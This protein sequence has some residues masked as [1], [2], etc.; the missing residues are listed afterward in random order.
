MHA[1]WQKICKQDIPFKVHALKSIYKFLTKSKCL[2]LSLAV[3]SFQKHHS[4]EIYSS[5]QT[6]L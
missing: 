1:C 6:G 2:V 5:F 4:Q 3:P